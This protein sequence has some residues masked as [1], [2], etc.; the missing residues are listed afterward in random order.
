M[1]L[2]GVPNATGDIWWDL[3]VAIQAHLE[4]LISLKQMQRAKVWRRVVVVE[5]TLEMAPSDEYFGQVCANLEDVFRN[6]TMGSTRLE[7]KSLNRLMEEFISEGF[8]DE[9]QEYLPHKVECSIMMGIESLHRLGEAV[10][11]LQADFEQV[12]PLLETCVLE[13]TNLP[14]S[15]VA[16][17]VFSRRVQRSGALG[18]TMGFLLGLAFGLA[19]A[20]CAII[21]VL[22]GF[23]AV[24]FEVSKII[25]RKKAAVDLVPSTLRSIKNIMHDRRRFSDLEARFAQ[26]LANASESSF[27]SLQDCGIPDEDI[28]EYLRV[29]RNKLKEVTALVDESKPLLPLEQKIMTQLDL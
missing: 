17:F 26:V 7:T 23:E 21:C 6:K 14:N 2:R 5:E 11:I 16:C 18:I 15:V 1:A 25:Q 24:R 22:I 28:Q 10:S 12:Q 3:L 4:T 29:L 8:R 13:A 19:G 9:P 20:I 27:M